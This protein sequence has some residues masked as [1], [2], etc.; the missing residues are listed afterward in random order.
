MA[1]PTSHWADV[2]RSKP[3]VRVRVYAG[4][5]QDKTNRDDRPAGRLTVGG[6]A[7]ECR[8]YGLRSVRLMPG[9]SIRSN[10]LQGVSLG[11]QAVGRRAYLSGDL[12]PRSRCPL[13]A[14]QRR[15]LIEAPA[16]QNV[17]RHRL[18]Q[19]RRDHDA[20]IHHRSHVGRLA[21]ASFDCYSGSRAVCESCCKTAEAVRGFSK[22][23]YGSARRN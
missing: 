12:R 16:R 5:S 23:R 19:R 4:Y 22:L 17:W 3:V 1:W 21:C 11:R 7:I 10:P 2:S 18:D 8:A 14:Q 6:Y 13:R 20:A 9:A 15:H